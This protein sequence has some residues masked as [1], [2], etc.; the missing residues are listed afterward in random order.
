MLF[1]LNGSD[2]SN[3]DDNENMWFGSNALHA[4]ERAAAILNKED[5]LNAVK[6]LNIEKVT[7]YQK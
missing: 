5:L 4:L 1:P 7:N 3:I 2:E 6:D